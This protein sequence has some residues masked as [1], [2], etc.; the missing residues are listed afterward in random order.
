MGVNKSVSKGAAYLYL[1]TIIVMIS[2]YAFWIVASK[3]TSPHILGTASAIVSLASIFTIVASIGI[4]SGIQRFIGK[5]FVCQDHA[6]AEKWISSAIFIICFGI[7]ASCT[8][9][10]LF[11]GWIYDLFK[12]DFPLLLT[13]IALICSS[14]IVSLFRSVIISSLQ[15]KMMPLVMLISTSMKLI[16]GVL[17]VFA[18]Y[19]ALGLTIGYTSTHVLS[20]AIFG[21]VILFSFRSLPKHSLGNFGTVKDL[22]LSSSASWIPLL[23]TTIGTQVGTLVVFGIQGSTQAGIYFMA[24]TIITGITG[25]TYSIL[26][27]A[28]PAL[29]GMSDGRKRFIW[30]AIRLSVLLTMPF[31]CSLLF[32]TP[33]LMALLGTGYIDGAIS[34]SI[35]ILS[36]LPTAIFTGVNSLVYANGKYRYVLEI[37]LAT[38]IPRTLLYFIL[39]P[40]LGALGAAVAYTVGSLTGLASAIRISNRIG[41]QYEWRALICMF[42][43]PFLLAFFLYL[44]HMNFVISIVLNIVISYIVLMLL[45]IISRRDLAEIFNA[46]PYGLSDSV[47]ALQ[48]R[49]NRSANRFRADD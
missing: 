38:S 31:S 3:I 9:L 16:I 12:I 15:T 30:Y 2:G 40:E 42:V 13:G 25:I 4:P 19:G 47:Q 49:I 46:L 14:T 32:I 1:E 11:S 7:F 6:E 34:L 27:I 37:G 17:L 24:L 10:L 41:L 36:L 39:V 21:T 29:S 5:S 26:T 20:A 18:G 45:K 48:K 33:Q 22:L 8:Y 28:I 35:M 23:I 44:I 43:I